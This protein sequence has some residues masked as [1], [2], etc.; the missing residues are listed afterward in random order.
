[1]MCGT[2]SS[3]FYLADERVR[4]RLNAVKMHLIG[5]DVVMCVKKFN[6]LEIR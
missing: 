4:M 3:K 5:C 6:P 1:M 2:S